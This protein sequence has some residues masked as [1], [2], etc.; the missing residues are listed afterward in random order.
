MV[1]FFCP[2]SMNKTNPRRTD[3]RRRGTLQFVS[4]I[5][6]NFSYPLIKEKNKTARI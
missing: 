1:F 6:N 3:V 5:P 4:S 2:F